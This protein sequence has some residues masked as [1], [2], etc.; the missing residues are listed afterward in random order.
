MGCFLLC[1]NVIAI[2]GCLP[3]WVILRSACFHVMDDSHTFV[4]RNALH[5]QGGWCI[6]GFVKAPKTLGGAS[7]ATWQSYV[8]PRLSL[9]A[10]DARYPACGDADF[11][12]CPT[13][14][15]VAG[16]LLVLDSV[17]EALKG[18]RDI[19]TVFE[20]FA[21]EW[22]DEPLQRHLGV[23]LLSGYPFSL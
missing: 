16:S 18:R 2:Q 4:H 20:S 11:G 21:T 19:V 1:Q 5:R 10:H 23:A 6:R 12:F 14:T 8:A 15:N 7:G 3:R 22:T 17:R 9:D 13:I